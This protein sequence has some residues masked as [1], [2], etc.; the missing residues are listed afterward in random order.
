M[1]Q[2]YKRVIVH[3]LTIPVIWTPFIPIVIL[4]IAIEIY[5]RLAFPI[6]KIPYVQRS[7]YIRMDRHK[8][9]YLTWYDKI[10]CSY[11]AY[12]SGF[13]YYAS[14]IAGRTEDY[15]CAIRHEE[16]GK[17]KASPH[18]KDFV[19]YGDNLAYEKRPSGYR[20]PR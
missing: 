1:R 8:L 6:Y 3:L 16:I 7:E 11:C 2:D 12:A 14:T 5:H 13:F 18:H 20:R 10:N 4:D 15:W 9:K 17:F 19:P